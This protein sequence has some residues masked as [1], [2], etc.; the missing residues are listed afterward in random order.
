MTKNKDEGKSYLQIYPELR[1]WINQCVACQREGYKPNMPEDIFP[2]VAA[3]NIRKYF[4]ELELNEIG[5]CSI[6][7]RA[8]QDPKNR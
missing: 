4:R 6:C 5:L 2:G 7:A 1:K 3:E 8:M